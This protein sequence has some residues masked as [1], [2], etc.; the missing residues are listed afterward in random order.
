MPLRIGQP[1]DVRVTADRLTTH[2]GDEARAYPEKNARDGWRCHRDGDHLGTRGC[3]F[4]QTPTGH[5]SV[6]DISI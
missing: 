1:F 3:N 2:F 5:L 6:H 4:H